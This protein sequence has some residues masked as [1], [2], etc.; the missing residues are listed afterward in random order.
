MSLSRSALLWMSQ[1]NFLRTT[2]PRFGFVR[3]AVRR[4]MPG[5]Q[6]EDAL[7]AAA[8]LQSEGLP[9]ILTHLGE[10]ISEL[11]EAE[12]VTNHYLD[13][14]NQVSQRHLDSYISVKLTQIGFD[15]DTEA[16]YKFFTQLAT[17]ARELGNL[18]WIDIESSAYTEGTIEFYRRAKKQF[19][20]T[21]VCLQSYLYRTE[22]DLMELLA[23]GSRIRLVKGAYKEPPSIAMPKKQDVDENFFVCARKI[24]AHTQSSGIV[25]G[26]GTH[27]MKLIR[28]II[29]EAN[30]MGLPREKYEF[31]MLYG[32]RSADQRQL[33]SEGYR[34]RVLISYGT[35]WYPWYLRRLAERPANVWFVVKNLLARG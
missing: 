28:R 5:E 19:E 18:V 3:N 30:R 17:R 12:N 22:R 29:E 33:R 6:L 34:V 26:I 23:E 24:L 4:F 7:T 27:D 32:I 21:G 16:C 8:A 15:I 2:F 1:N 14:A 13:V 9:T 20:N 31:Q 10:N 35:Y 25:H 11:R